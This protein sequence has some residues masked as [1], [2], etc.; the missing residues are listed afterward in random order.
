MPTVPAPPDYYIVIPILD[1]PDEAVWGSVNT[2]VATGT[3]EEEAV[4][5]VRSLAPEDAK[6]FIAQ[7]SPYLPV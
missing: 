1:H 4:A 2:F 6:G 7:R 5:K 3:S